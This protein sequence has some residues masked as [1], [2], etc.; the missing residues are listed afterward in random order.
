MLADFLIR[1]TSD[2]LTCAG[3]APR[4]GAAQGDAR[5]IPRAAVAA[6]GGRIVFIGFESLLEREV[7]LERDA[8][9]LDARGGAV[10]PGFVDPHTH[11]VFAGD[12]REE[13]RRR[14]TGTTYAQIAAEGGGILGTVVATRAASD[15][16]LASDTRRRLDEMLRCGIT[17]CE[18]KSGY[19]LTT[20]GELKMLRVVR[21]LAADHAIELSSTFMGAHEVPAE[22]RG[23]RRDYINL[24]MS[25]MI[26]AVAR[27]GLAEW[28]D[29][30]CE[31]G[32]FTP[33]ES[34]EIL[35]AG[36][37]AG[38]KL[39][40][41]ADE[42]GPSGGSVVA[43][44]L[45][46]RSADHLIFVDVEGADG[47]AAAGVVATLLPIASFYLKLGRFAPGRMLIER[48]VP[49]ALATDINPGGGLSPSMP[50]AM[51]LACFGM[52]LTFEEALVGAT[53]NAAYSLDRHER[54]GS[55]EPGKQMDAVVV[56]GPAIDLIRVGADTIRAVVKKGRVVHAG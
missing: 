26:P 53:I 27:E 14:L 5:S 21:T 22:Y 17:T 55:L 50:F 41:H 4:R 39:R 25:E 12:R 38:L 46:V 30:F 45:G 15:D 42:L 51:A 24:L 2:V 49:V 11:V 40:I 56:R 20:E 48:G 16:Q 3:P 36:R 31:T 54:V 44:E 34:R 9:V 8:V 32:V 6:R 35:Q 19:G 52:N 7:E 18:A 10:V 47:L 33:D 1:N 37:D 28:C 13:L 23:R 29:V 43:A